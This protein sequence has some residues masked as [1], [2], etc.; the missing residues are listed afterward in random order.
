MIGIVG[1]GITGL[2]IAHHLREQGVDHVVFEADATAGGVIRTIRRGG[3]PLEL[4]PQRT[5]LTRELRRL[6]SDLDLDGELITAPPGLP[7]YVYRRGRLRRVP[8]TPGAVLGTDLISWGAKLRLLLEPFTAGPKEHETVEAYFARKVG[9]E[10]YEALLGPLYG[11]LYA[12]DP[13]RMLVRHGLARLL[14]QLGVRRS[15]VLSW[16]RAGG[17]TSRIPACSFRNGMQAL[18]LALAHRDRSNVRF[19][20]PVRRVV[21]DHV[22]GFRIETEG[23]TVSVRSVVVTASADATA[24]M[25]DE[26]APDA[27]RRLRALTYNPLAMVHLRSGAPLEGFGYQVAFGED[28]QTRG[29]TWN[30]SLFRRPG[31]FTAFLGGMKNPG[32]VELPSLRLGEI[33]ADEFAR[34]TGHEAEVLHVHRTRVPAWD[35]TWR[36][37]EGLGLPPRLRICSNYWD[38]PGIPGRLRQAERVAREL[39]ETAITGAAP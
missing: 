35:L 15:L 13:G 36:G 8:L 7:L 10:P 24:G 11:G 29:V 30:A 31:L 39:A 28:L 22:H 27:A 9:T 37:L 21:R 32:L 6:V 3:V 5:R 33:A 4:G 17:L 19:G 12:T 1:A 2:A 26:M 25:I 23:P 16:I 38:R 14:T 34:V 20:T 18:P